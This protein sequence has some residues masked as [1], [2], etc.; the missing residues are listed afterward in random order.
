MKRSL[1]DFE[2][3][4]MMRQNNQCAL[5]A[6]LLKYEA[7]LWKLSYTYYHQR[8]PE[9]VQVHDLYQEGRLGL[10]EALYTYQESRGVGLAHYVKVCVES[11]IASALRKCNSKSYQLLDTRLSLDINISEDESLSFLDLMPCENLEYNPHYQAKRNE[12][13]R[14]LAYRLSDLSPDEYRIYTLWNKG[15]SYKEM[16]FKLGCETKKIDNTI[17]KIKRLA[18]GQ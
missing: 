2:Y 14:I 1:T 8:K 3:L 4:Y 5:D 10:I 18:Q 7:L 11:H 15:F 12:S 16:A 17:Q 6:L 13:K 9:G